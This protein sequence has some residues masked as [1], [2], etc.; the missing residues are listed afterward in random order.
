MVFLNRLKGAYH[1]I[2]CLIAKMMEKKST[3]KFKILYPHRIVALH[4]CACAHTKEYNF[5]ISHSKIIQLL[6]CDA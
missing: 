3:Y 1:R 4:T 5:K 2:I 6:I